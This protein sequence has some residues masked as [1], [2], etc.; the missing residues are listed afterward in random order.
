MGNEEKEEPKS[1]AEKFKEAFFWILPYLIAIVIVLFLK[2]FVF[3]LATIP[4][5]SMLNTLQ[6]DDKVYGNRLAYMSADP[7]RGDIVI[8]YHPD[9]GT[10]YIKRCIGL[11]GDKVVIKD[12]KVYINDST[13]PLEEDYL[14][15]EW[16]IRA[17][18][19][20]YH[21]PE[22]SFFMMGDNRNGSWDSRCW[23]TSFVPRENIIARADFIYWPLSHAGKLRNNNEK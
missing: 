13:E 19:Y 12:A 10:R 23:V 11:P 2:T 4:S 14:M 9:D 22:N 18:D 17:N 1:R 5:S 7:Q 21:V 20:E 8:F 16:Y 3:I 15:E 6:L